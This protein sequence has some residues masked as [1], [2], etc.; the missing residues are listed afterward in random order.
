M[1]L[2]CLK[3]EKLSPFLLFSAEDISQ[4]P[5]TKKPFK[6]I[7]SLYLAVSLKAKSTQWPR[8]F[9]HRSICD[10]KVNLWPPENIH[11]RNKNSTVHKR[12]KLETI[13]MLI[14]NKI[15]K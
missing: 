13:Q 15:G 6:N 10:S 8:N 3:K 9:T 7:Y 2:Y 12:H 14:N 5:T 1:T 11:K 4:P